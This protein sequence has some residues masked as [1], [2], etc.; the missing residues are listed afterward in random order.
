MLFV[1][2]MSE[3]QASLC[4][5]KQ[6]TSDAVKPTYLAGAETLQVTLTASLSFITALAWNELFK[7]SF[8]HF[9]GSF[10]KK[11][12]YR[13]MY[14]IIVTSFL[15]FFNICVSK[16]VTEMRSKAQMNIILKKDQDKQTKEQKSQK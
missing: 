4:V 15:F 8:E 6:Y 2:K 13:L 12:L 9:V 7:S 14:A 10:W 16:C 3:P 5:F 1:I 11:S